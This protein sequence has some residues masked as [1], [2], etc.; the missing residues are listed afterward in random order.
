MR[1]STRI[2]TKKQS[3]RRRY[4]TNCRRSNRRC[5]VRRRTRKQYGA[6]GKRS[7]LTMDKAE[8]EWRARLEANP[9]DREWLRQNLKFAAEQNA[10]RHNK[11]QEERNRLFT[12]PSIKDISESAQNAIKIGHN[13]DKLKGYAQMADKHEMHMDHAEENQKALLLQNK[14]LEILRKNEKKARQRQEEIAYNQEQPDTGSPLLD[15]S[16]LDNIR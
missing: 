2:T 6:S 8:E 13:S 7:R 5:A 16:I 10:K 11:I 15:F 4:K 3:R 14:M 9:E 12:A 1:K